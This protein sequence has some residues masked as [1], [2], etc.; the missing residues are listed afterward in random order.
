MSDG[1]SAEPKR[2]R[3]PH[4]T[5][6]A[7][8]RFLALADHGTAGYP[9]KTRRRL[10]NINVAAYTIAVS[11][12]LFALTFALQDPTVY[13]GPV[14]VNIAMALA[15]LVLPTLHRIHE[16]A[17]AVLMAFSL[18]VGLFVIVAMVG[19][20]S[21]I[22]INL[23]AAPVLAFLFI[24]LRRLR[25]IVAITIAGM[26]LHV[27]A[28]IFF[29]QGMVADEAA[30]AFLL[31][32]YITTVV[33]ITIIVGIGVYYAFW[34]AERAEAETEMLLHRILPIAVADRL[35]ARPSEPISDSFTE[36]A[37]LFSDLVGFVEI[38]R[39]LGARRTVEMLN[40]LVHR[41]DR[42]AAEHGVEKIKTIGDAYMAAAIGEGSARERAGRLGRMA[43]RMQAEADAMAAEFDIPLKLRIGIALGPVMAGV[44][45]AQRFTYDI[46]GDAVNLAARLESAGEAGR[47]QVSAA[48][49]DALCE[50]F[51]FEPRGPIDIKGVGREET[52]FLVGE[53]R[54]AGLKARA[55]DPA[56]PAATDDAGGPDGEASPAVGRPS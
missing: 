7:G 38:A 25:L 33:T 30:D 4:L 40:G 34:T 51:A 50:T 11:C 15:M 1:S 18:I 29:P 37:V 23:I 49:H 52:W 36:V 47:I 53:T 2:R 31:Q 5:S 26:I 13:R 56:L 44:I 32:L 8:G 22:Q 55:S 46:W 10:R 3:W 24:E 21:G 16:T 27:T 19:R 39:S 14:L 35:K 12:L 41:L 28:W 20:D 42:L 9:P 45:G 6:A 48:F 43:L 17:G 54:A